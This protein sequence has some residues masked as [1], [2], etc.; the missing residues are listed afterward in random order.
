MFNF[1]IFSEESMDDG[2]GTDSC[3]NVTVKLIYST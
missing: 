3:H 1:G 2:A